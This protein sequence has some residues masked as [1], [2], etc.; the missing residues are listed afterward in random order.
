M[1]EAGEEGVA[2]ATAG[3]EGVAEAAGVVGLAGVA[4]ATIGVGEATAEE[5]GAALLEGAAVACPK[6]FD[7]R[8]V[9][10][11]IARK[12][13]PLPGQKTSSSCSIGRCTKREVVSDD[14]PDAP[15]ASRSM[16]WLRIAC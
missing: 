1:A 16:F 2:E 13:Y 5:A 3:E 8:L 14:R 12:T 10:I 4:A 6:I 15:P 9:N 11:P 7:M